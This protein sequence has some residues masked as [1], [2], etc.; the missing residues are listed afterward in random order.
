MPE[1]YPRKF[2]TTEGYSVLGVGGTPTI[3]SPTNVH[4][5]VAVGSTIS[6]VGIVSTTNDMY[7]G[8]GNTQG[9]ILTAPNGTK[10]RVTVDN[11]GNLQTASV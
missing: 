8:V 10:Y 7:V 6:L 3:T 2:A 11:S 5:K 9:M 1:G 4:V